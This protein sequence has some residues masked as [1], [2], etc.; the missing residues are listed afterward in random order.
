MFDIICCD[1]PWTHHVW[2]AARGEGRTSQSHYDCL[3][4][5]EL[6]ALDIK[7]KLAAKDCVLFL[8]TTGPQMQN[9]LKLIAAWGFQFKTIAFT[10]VKQN[11]KS[12]SLFWG[13]GHYTRANPEF[14][15]LATRGKTLKRMSK[16]VHSIIQSPI[17]KHSEKPTEI[18][19]RIDALFGDNLSKIEL[20]ARRQPP[21]A[22]WQATGLEWDGLDIREFISIGNKCLAGGTV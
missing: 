20:F 5:E 21:T 14:C 22:G 10:W 16:S 3:T 15:L 13:M 18:F 9:A 6:E 1:P 8:W 19:S 12:S 17:G 11:K 4:Q 2:P 7:S